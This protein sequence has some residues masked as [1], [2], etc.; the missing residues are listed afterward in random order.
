[1]KQLL[2]ELDDEIAAKL[3]QVAPGR[4]RRR[5]EFVRMAVRRALWD[6]EEQQ[7]AEAYRRMPDSA[8]EA[9]VDPAVWE[10]RRRRGAQR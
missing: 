3:E 7:T 5:S 6:L 4:A 9:H 8:A 1:M 10:P 2:V